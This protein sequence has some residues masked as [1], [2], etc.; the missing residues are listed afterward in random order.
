MTFELFR[1]MSLVSSDDIS[2]LFLI[3]LMGNVM[4]TLVPMAIP[5][6][7]FFSTIFSLSQMSGDSEY[8]AL[9]A[10]GLR[11]SQILKPYMLVG[12]VIA[13]VVY[14]F[15]QQ[16]VPNAHKQVRKKVKIIS[17]TSL[18]QGLKSGQFF[19]NLPNITIFPTTI[20]EVT[21]EFEDIFLHIYAPAEKLEKVILAKSGRILHNKDEKTGVESFKLFLKDGNIVNHIKGKSNLE[22]ILFKEYTLPISEQKFSYQTS[23]KEIMMNQAELKSFIDGGL[24]A[25]EK[26]GFKKKDFLNAKYEFWN[27]INTPILCLLLTFL[28]FGLGV[29]SNRGKSKSPSGKAILMLIGYYFV[30]FALVSVSR[31]GTIPVYIAML[32][33]G[34]LLFGI[35]VKF[36]RSMDWLS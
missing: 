32:I 3:G 2:M 27:R 31:E 4:T 12:V 30:Y 24:K 21:K 34:V 18:I 7:I 14:F 35:S 19:T 11:K 10:A 6:S 28:G 5:V 9:R 26:K 29:T 8:I 15:N 13:I 20:D 36:Y 22:K 17:S 23:I 33:P 16:L 1:I 25:A